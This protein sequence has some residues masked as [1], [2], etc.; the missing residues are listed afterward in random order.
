MK[1]SFV[2]CSLIVLFFRGISISGQKQSIVAENIFKFRIINGEKTSQRNVVQQNTYDM[3]NRMIRQ[4]FYNDSIPI[5]EDFTLFFYESDRLISKET[6]DMD[7]IQK[8]QRF[9]Y[10]AYG[11]PE[12]LTIFERYDGE[13]RK[14]Y[15][16]NNYYRDTLLIKQKKL[17]NHSKWLEETNYS[18]DD[19]QMTKKTKYRKGFNNDLKT[20]DVISWL[21][22]NK[23]VKS[24]IIL[25]KTNGDRTLEVIEYIYNDESGKLEREIYRNNEGENIQTKEYHYLANG[26][27]TSEEIFDN[28]G[29]YIEYKLFE[30]KYFLVDLGNPQMYQFK[31]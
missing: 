22:N 8:I 7:S 13:I 28:K 29:K 4:I 21:T 2:V 1:A 16:V 17:D 19:N 14:K 5:V 30:R 10:N 23:I 20:Q 6:F 11:L 24:Q 18:R 31:N 25:T 12:E 9:R 27:K 26:I 3:N 15:V